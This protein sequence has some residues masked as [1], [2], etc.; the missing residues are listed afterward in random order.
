M[1]AEQQSLKQSA[2]D[3]AS[4]VSREIRESGGRFAKDLA[5]KARPL[6]LHRESLTC[7]HASFFP[8]SSL[9]G[10]PLP[11]L[12]SAPFRPFPPRKAHC[13]VERQAQHRAWRGAQSLARGSFG[14]DLS[15]KF[16]KEIPSRNLR[17][18]SQAQ[19]SAP[20]SRDLC[21]RDYK[22]RRSLRF[23]MRS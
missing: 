18:K 4:R 11:L 12:I 16:G 6:N 15:T 20:K 22:G 13:S 1:Q 7:F 23:P 3:I 14:M 10:I 17:E 19:P 9:A 8:F 2:E 21:D 5:D